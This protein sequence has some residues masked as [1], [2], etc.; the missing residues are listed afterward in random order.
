MKTAF[1]KAGGG[2]K[3]SAVRSAVA[4][5][6]IIRTVADTHAAALVDISETGASLQGS[7]LPQKG[8]EIDLTIGALSAFGTVVWSTGSKCGV[9]FDEPRTQ[10]ELVRLRREAVIPLAAKLSVDERIALEHWVYGGAR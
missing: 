7:K 10:L 3:R 6:V 9:E 8:E 4:I 2:G 1:G 5:S